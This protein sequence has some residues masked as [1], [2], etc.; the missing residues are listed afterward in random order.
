MKVENSQNHL[1]I[2]KSLASTIHN[3]MVA[4]SETNISNINLEINGL[5]H[6]MNAL[7]DE[8]L[9]LADIHK[10]FSRFATA[11]LILLCALLA[12]LSYTVLI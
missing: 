2:V 6:R 1:E 12:V 5:T 10:R 8:L 4:P 3:K 7:E 9:L 11:G